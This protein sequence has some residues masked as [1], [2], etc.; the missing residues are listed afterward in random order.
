MSK[1]YPKHMIL[2]EPGDPYS[3]AREH[4]RLMEIIRGLKRDIEI[5][6]RG[7]VAL[8]E[9]LIETRDALADGKETAAEA[10]IAGAL[11]RAG[12]AY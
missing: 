6:E 11:S 9:A 2:M 8:I 3:P 10:I 5:R 7:R 4:D 1:K 12:V